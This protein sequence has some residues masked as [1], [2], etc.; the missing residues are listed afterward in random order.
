[1]KPRTQRQPP[2][3][4]PTPRRT[5]TSA[6]TPAE[7]ATYTDTEVCRVFGH[8]PSHW[9]HDPDGTLVLVLA[10]NVVGSDL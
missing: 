5:R 9:R 6:L 1:V 10:P 8:R 7:R 2:A 4:T 3:P